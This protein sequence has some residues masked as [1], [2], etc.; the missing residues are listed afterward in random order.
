MRTAPT[1][2]GIS[3]IQ[4]LS[5]GG[6][7]VYGDKDHV[8]AYSDYYGGDLPSANYWYGGYTADAEL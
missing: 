5:N 6:I 3:G 7:T 4:V 8:V 2:T 1:Y